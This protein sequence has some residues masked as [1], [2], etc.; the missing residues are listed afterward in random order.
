MAPAPGEFEV[1][2][3][4]TSARAPERKFTFYVTHDPTLTP[5]FTYVAML[6]ALTVLRASGRR[7]LDGGDTARCRSARTARSRFDDVFSG[8]AAPWPPRRAIAAADRHDR[9]Q[10]VHERHA[11]TAG[12]AD[13]HASEEQ[14]GTTI[15]RVWLDTTQ[16]QL[17]GTLQL[18]VQLHD[19]RGARAHVAIP[20]TMPT[21]A[22]GPLTL[23]VSDAATLAAL[24][25]RELRPGKPTSFG[26]SAGAD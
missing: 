26:R 8:T 22:D 13:S 23:L 14:Q 1:H 11:R 24:E 10:R 20:I 4:L 6:N 25:Q 15:E 19:Y 2:L 7:R 18:Q 9:R 5:L 3:S 12:P 17:G 16:P 21:Q